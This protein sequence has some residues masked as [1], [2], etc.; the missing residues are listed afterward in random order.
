M[1]KQTT[2][3]TQNERCGTDKHLIERIVIP[4]FEHDGI[5][6]INDDCLNCIDSLP[7]VD[8]V[9]T[10][11]PYNFNLRIH[12]GR[13]VRRSVK[14]RTKYKNYYHDALSMDEYFN[15]QKNVIEKL[16]NKTKHNIFYNIQMI[17]G[18]KRALLKLMGYFSNSAICLS[19]QFKVNPPLPFFTD[20][21]CNSINPIKLQ[22]VTMQRILSILSHK[23]FNTVFTLFAACIVH[24][25]GV[26]F[27]C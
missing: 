20:L 2:N 3:N 23:Y 4:P 12:S 21:L 1:T 14:E 15:W 22:P 26:S 10:S 19:T 25:T 8:S 11:P 17:T 27:F 13:Y 6:V 18:N 16:L 9:V 24:V 7:P 5:T